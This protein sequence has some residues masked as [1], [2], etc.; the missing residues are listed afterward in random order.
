MKPFQIKPNIYWIGIIDWNLRDFHGYSQT[1][2][3]TTYNAYLILDDKIT[4]LDTVSAEYKHDFLH[5]LSS[6][7]DPKKIDYLVV[8][9]VEPDH[10]GSLSYIVEHVQPEKIF[11]SAMGYRFIQGRF[12]TDNWPL[13]KVKSEQTINLGSRH[14]Q[15]LET[16]MLHWPDSMVSYV[17]EDKLLIS[18]DAFGQNIAS[19][20]LF[21]HDQDWSQLKQEMANY[22]ANII[23][24]YSSNVFQAL[25]KIKDLGWEIEMIAPDHG[26]ILEKYIPQAVQAYQEFARQKPRLKAVIF[27]DT[28]WQ[29]TWKMA[30]AL[31]S[32][33]GSQGIEVKLFN[34]KK[35]HHS[36]VMNHV[37]DTA[38]VLAGSPTHN[39]GL[40]PLVANML[41]YMQ[42]LRPKNKLGAAF[43]SYG[44][45]GEA[46][47][48]IQEWLQQ[49]GMQTV[50][51]PIRIQHVPGQE[52][53]QHLERQ[54]EILAGHIR[55][56]VQD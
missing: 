17:P 33:L 32:A 9:H 46:P 16:R 35:W 56:M 12:Q 45:S 7:I 41:T 6:I 1:R 42:G 39:N 13:E 54:A 49:M 51:E 26:L 24:P 37:W 4:L 15:F 2:Q 8:N 28:M 10:A 43:G 3:G 40:M 36:E 23:L 44:W 53:Y 47:A 55:D 50:L 31:A 14:I 34:L 5:H 18:Q 52:D 22:F 48:K 11:C 20:R 21:D 29:S 38:A 19:T 30:G 27:Y 25:Q